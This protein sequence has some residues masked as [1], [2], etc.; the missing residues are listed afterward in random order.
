VKRVVFEMIFKAII[1]AG[2][3]PM[4]ILNN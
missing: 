2:F 3:Y 4:Y 1:I